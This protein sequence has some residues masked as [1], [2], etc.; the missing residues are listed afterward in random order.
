MFSF[1]RLWN[2]EGGTNSVVSPMDVGET[3]KPLIVVVLF[4]C[5]LAQPPSSNR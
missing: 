3:L 1:G 4:V 5:Q 2:V